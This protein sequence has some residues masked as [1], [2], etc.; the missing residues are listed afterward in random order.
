MRIHG[1]RRTVGVVATAAALVLATVWWTTPA[2]GGA[3]SATRTAQSVDRP[4]PRS[5]NLRLCG[6]SHADG[7]TTVCVSDAG[8]IVRFESP[9]GYEHIGVGAFSEGYVLC[10]S[11]LEA[12][13]VGESQ[14]NWG[15]P[16]VTPGP[17]SGLPGPIHGGSIVRVAG[18]R[19]ELTQS[20]AFDGPGKR[21]AI[22]MSVRNV[23]P[24]PAT[25]VV[26][27]RQVDFD[28]DTGGTHGWAG[29]D[30]QHARTSQDSVFAWNSPD[31]SRGNEAHSMTLRTIDRAAQPPAHRAAVTANI[32]ET[33][34]D[35]EPSIATPTSGDFGETLVYELGTLEP[36]QRATAIV[37][38]LRS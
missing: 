10:A 18:G 27:R 36:G 29:F 8:N 11:G 9:R 25:N 23:G 24:D 37:E 6:N 5:V 35:G 17:G 30:N 3:A 19:L 34:C 4:M 7:G 1:G 21:L 20:F 28:V 22:T 2:Q 16:F 12:F 33:S 15:P 13:D 14:S 31:A 32:L 38:Y 26:L